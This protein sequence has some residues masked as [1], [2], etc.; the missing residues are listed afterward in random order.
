MNYPKCIISSDLN[1][2]ALRIEKK[3]INF[4]RKLHRLCFTSEYEIRLK[5]T[6]MNVPDDVDWFLPGFH[7]RGRESRLILG[8][9]RILPLERLR[10][11]TS[12]ARGLLCS[13]TY[14]GVHGVVERPR[15]LLLFFLFLSPA[16][17]Q[18]IAVVPFSRPYAIS[19]YRAIHAWTRGRQ[20]A[21]FLSPSLRF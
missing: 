4:F 11:V 8:A 15:H 14:A 2:R 16:A 5:E 10:Q 21:L 13:R 1:S 12:V 6:L 9:F 19:L 18:Q 3:N 17:R 20:A 7:E